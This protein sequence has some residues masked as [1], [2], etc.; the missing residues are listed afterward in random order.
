MNIESTILIIVVV[1][2]LIAVAG[3]F[4]FRNKLFEKGPVLAKQSNTQIAKKGFGVYKVAYTSACTTPNNKC[5]T[6]GTQYQ[7]YFCEPHPETGNGCIND[8]GEQ[9]FEAKTLTSSCQSNCRS[10]IL[11]EYETAPSNICR[12]D[13]VNYTVNG[14]D[15]TADFNSPE[16]NC[17]PPNAVNPFFYRE[18]LCVKNDSIGDNAC[19]YKCGSSGV[20]PEGLIGDADI[21]KESYIPTCD[22]TFNPPSTTSKSKKQ[23]KNRTIVLNSLPWT[24]IFELPTNGV[25][26]SKGYTIKNIK[27]VNGKIDTLNFSITP[28]YPPW[29]PTKS[30]I[31]KFDDLKQLDN[32]FT[33]Y[34]N[35]II[36]PTYEKPTCDNYYYF[37]PVKPGSNITS[38]PK[39][40][41]CQL[42]STFTPT[43]VCFYNPWNNGFVGQDVPIGNTGLYFQNPYSGPTGTTASNS[44]VGIGN[45]GYFASALSCL[46][47]PVP[48]KDKGVTG[49]NIPFGAIDDA[50][51]LNLSSVIPQCSVDYTGL[52]S[53]IPN[54]AISDLTPTT[55]TT[56]TSYP[57]NP[58]TTNYICSTKLPNGTS[59]ID[60]SGNPVPGCIKTCQYLPTSSDI[61]FDAKDYTGNSLNSAFVP[62]L[63]KYVHLYYNK[64]SDEYFLGTKTTPCGQNFG[65]TGPLTNCLGSS[66]FV[67]TECMY[68][69]SGGSDMNAGEFWSKKGCDQ[70]SIEN[71][72]AMAL[73]FSP[74]NANPDVGTVSSIN[75]D[76][77]ANIAGFYGYLSTESLNI[78]SL[79]ITS[80]FTPNLN[81]V[82]NTTNVTTNIYFNALNLGQQIPLTS[83]P[84]GKPFFTL[85]YDSSTQVYTLY[86]YGATSPISVSSYDGTTYTTFDVPLTF[87]TFANKGP[88]QGFFK[89]QGFND[90]V[91]K[92]TGT[93]IGRDVSRTTLLQRNNQCYSKKNCENVISLT[94]P[95]LC[96]DTTCNLYYEFTP[97]FCG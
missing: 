72:T 26:M 88:N 41:V 77:Y 17:I 5:N 37:N 3:F 79:N 35:C 63:G 60:S 51:C 82:A 93:Y 57:Q 47:G 27:D 44:W 21:N 19:T 84:S 97:E 80:F 46:P 96:Y 56:L 55:Q 54:Q 74:H 22:N 16:Y 7:S 12:Y 64:G 67:P 36:N 95:P 75:C 2:V 13:T 65:T 50:T 61:N 92:T 49:Y 43:P 89:T 86:R 39:P 4:I 78:N 62:L 59:E 20:T 31:I 33:V 48:L 69:Y 24:N 8:N 83:Y 58:N 38:N 53:V 32:T 45:Y 15:F 90:I 70:E 18:F 76:I 91:V 6:P 1:I 94:T 25:V 29:S 14:E 52:F 87:K 9:T 68:I 28:A 10:Y 42:G 30:N 71:A 73:V 11:Q 23:G 34:D 81:I 85:Q 66:P 40:G